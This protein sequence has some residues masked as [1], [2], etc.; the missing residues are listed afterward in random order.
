MRQTG[1]QQFQIVI[2][3][4]NRAYSGS[5]ALYVITLLDGDRRR[6]TLNAVD[7][8]FVHPIQKLPG[9]RTERFH[10]PTLSLRI[11]GVESET[12]FPAPAGSGHHNELAQRQLCVKTGEIIL[13]GTPNPDY[14]INSH[15]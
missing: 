8:G 15:K 5:G 10:I 11:D 13:P 12:G 14:R 1:H 6:N 4:G 9:I 2:D 7:P 3:F